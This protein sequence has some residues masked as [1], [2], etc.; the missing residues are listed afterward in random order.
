M[1]MLVKHCILEISMRRKP[2]LRLPYASVVPDGRSPSL[3][4]G[5]DTSIKKSSRD[6]LGDGT[7]IM[8]LLLLLLHDEL[9]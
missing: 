3:L 2:L 6:W 7:T 1:K 5:G 8:L 9:V 4:I